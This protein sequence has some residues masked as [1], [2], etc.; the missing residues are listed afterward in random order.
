[1]YSPETDEYK[2]L[3]KMF[4]DTSIW[5]EFL[6]YLKTNV[7][8]EYEADNEVTLDNEDYNQKLLLYIYTN[9]SIYTEIAEQLLD[10]DEGLQEWRYRHVKIVERMIGSGTV[11]TGGSSGFEYLKNT[12]TLSFCSDLWK[13]RNYFYG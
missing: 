11:G 9:H 12:I 8:L 10:F 2:K 1:M 5:D 13:V 7:E 6:V 4:A 3:C